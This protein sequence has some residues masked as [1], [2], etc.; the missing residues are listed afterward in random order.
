LTL[1]LLVGSILL[2]GLMMLS[3]Y[4]LPHRV[5]AFLAGPRDL[6]QADIYL[7]DV[8]HAAIV[9]LTH[10]P[11]HYSIPIWSPDGSQLAFTTFSDDKGGNLVVMDADG[12][13][14]RSV[15]RN[16]YMTI[17]GPAWSP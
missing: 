2:V 8:D 17:E 16:G 3:R 7:L 12:T 5:V 4:V 1:H 14:A 11:A 13:N 15:I 9:G 6:T 10:Q